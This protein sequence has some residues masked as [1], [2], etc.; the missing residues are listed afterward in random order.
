M[1]KPARAI[2]LNNTYPLSRGLIGYWL[3]NE[4]GARSRSACFFSSNKISDLSLNRN[5]L[6]VTRGNPLWGAGQ[7]GPTIIGDGDDDVYSTIN[8]LGGYS[9]LTMLIK[10]RPLEEVDG[11]YI[12]L[13]QQYSAD[14]NTGIRFDATQRAR[15]IIGDAI[16][17]YHRTDS[18]IGT[19]TIGTWVHIVMS[20]DGSG[21]PDVYINSVLDNARQASSGTVVNCN[22]DVL[23]ILSGV[24]YRAN[25][26]VEY[27][28]LWDRALTA[29]EIVHVYREPFCMFRY[30]SPPKF[31]AGIV[32]PAIAPVFISTI[33]D[34]WTIKQSKGLFT[35]V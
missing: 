27:A 24:K 19:L 15:C 8:I 5:N 31:A 35:K 28:A 21:S 30:S 2:Q 9:Q 13:G 4:G 6:S 11:G 33:T 1:L 22:S 7:S 29:S 20:W 14:I 3:M 12:C 34:L 10:V 32:P 17:D 18:S 16:S 26:E 23:N 25:I